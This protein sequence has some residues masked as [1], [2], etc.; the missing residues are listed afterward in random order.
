[1][2]LK[3]NKKP[4]LGDTRSRHHFFL[5]PMEVD[6]YFYWLETREVIE[7]FKFLPRGIFGGVFR[8]LHGWEIIEVGDVIREL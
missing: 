1:M 8:C 5:V 7:K 2:R 6:R 4:G 3:L